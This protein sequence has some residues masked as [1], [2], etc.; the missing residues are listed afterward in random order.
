MGKKVEMTAEEL[1]ERLI[2]TNR[3]FHE[4]FSDEDY[5]MLTAHI[6][7]RFLEMKSFGY[8]NPLEVLVDLLNAHDDKGAFMDVCLKEL[9][10]SVAVDVMLDG[11]WLNAKSK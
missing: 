10:I 4:S 1:T 7:K 5:E 9:T 6:R 11:G 3:M 8:E 2:E